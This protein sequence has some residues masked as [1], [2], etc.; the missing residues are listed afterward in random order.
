M[1]RKY[2]IDSHPQK[3]KVIKE[4]IQGRK[5]LSAIARQYN[6]N[7]ATVQRYLE[8]RLMKKAA[9]VQVERDMKD[10][11]LV[12]REIDYIMS[13]MKKLYD[14]CDEYLTDPDNQE[15]YTLL[16][17]AWEAEICF[18]DKTQETPIQKRLSVQALIDEMREH[19]KEFI[20]IKYK[21]HDPRKMVTETAGVLTKQLELLAR[22][23]G[24]IKDVSISIINNP[25]WVEVQA[26]IL[27]TVN[28]YPEIKDRLA[29]EFAKIS[30]EK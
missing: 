12:Y 5:S 4:I 26:V 2:I 19:G 11:Q 8:T 20:E 18:L 27:N 29:A 3:E 6:I 13:R 22:I 30:G 1:P 10:S 23:Q 15:K 9:K 28:R 25:A 7:K 17:R 21:Y 14:A 16:P 24:T